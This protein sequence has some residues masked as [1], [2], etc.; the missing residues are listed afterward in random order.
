MGNVPIYDDYSNRLNSNCYTVGR[1]GNS[2]LALI[3]HNTAGP[4]DKNGT[5]AKTAQRLSDA[6][7]AYLAS[8]DRQASVHWLVGAEACGAP[9]YKI[10][11]EASTAYHCG[12][13]PP[14][15]PSSWKDPTSGK[16]YGGF[17]L[18]QVTIGIEV[19]GQVNETLG[20]NQRAALFLLVQDIVTRNPIL[21]DPLRTEAC[22]SRS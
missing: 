5:D 18:N 7:A 11:P 9:I 15:Y 3:A 1:G 14:Q 21:K 10:V 4:N 19:F 8:N 16:V 13:N 17:G 2:V 6:S 12:G 20:P 22:R